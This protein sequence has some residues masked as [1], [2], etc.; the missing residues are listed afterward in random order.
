LQQ[1][2]HQPK[3]HAAP[4]PAPA[5]RPKATVMIITYNHA[6]YIAQA[7]ESVLAQKTS[8][9]F[10]I[11]VIDDCSTD[12]A[13]DVIRDYAAR[14][15]GVV[16]PFIN[17]KNIGSKVTQR[18]FHR[19]FST[20]D[21]DYCAILE[22]DDYW[23][24]PRRLQTHV[25]FL[26]AHLDFVGCANNTMK[27]YEDGS[28]REPHLLL[29]PQAKEEHDIHDL[30][31]IRSFFHASSLTFRNVFRGR[32]PRYLR[33]P[34]S[35]DI[36]I[37][38]AHA[39]F[40]KIRYFHDVGSVYRAHADGLFSQMSPTKGYMWNI[41]SFRAF[42]RWLGFRY[43]R[44]FARSI[45]NYCDILEQRGEPE[46]GYTPE[47]RAYYARVRRRYR[48]LEKAWLRLDLW[49]ARVLPGRRAASAPGRL[50]LGCGHR[51]P[52]TMT[53][54]DVRGDVDPD[55]TVDLQRTPWP[56][57]DD[58]AEEVWFEKSLEHMAPDFTTFQ[59][60]MAEL[61]RI[62]RPGARVV[63]TAKHPWHNSFVHD[64][65]CVRTISPVVMSLFD[66]ATPLSATPEPVA[67]KLGVDFEVAE[68]TVNLDEPYRSRFLGGQ[69]SLE[70]ATRLSETTLNV[71][72]DFRIELV[73]HK[74]PRPAPA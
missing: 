54:V 15:P 19:G 56:F 9:P 64:P 24:S 10:A 46:G 47:N 62:C 65:T 12:G 44:A 3:V 60:M 43:F 33:S 31:M 8:F 59:A 51:R 57:P 5:G 36:F 35:C 73:A 4:P 45:W 14:Y 27:I 28:G 66:A 7:I 68:R 1:T 22:G 23:A 70:E 69:L 20:L 30:I 11:H 38:I 29:P 74:P 49:L 41:D 32:V 61:H 21:G 48:W 6:K 25:D 42:N 17:K 63:I 34:L 18:N 50:N 53:N 52:L 72:S 37:T 26:D 2:I 55:L 40:G 71:C 13:Q 16:K 67:A 58:Y 39:Q